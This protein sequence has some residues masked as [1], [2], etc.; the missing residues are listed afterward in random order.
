VA[1]K[2]ASATVAAAVAALILSLDM[3]FLSLVSFFVVR[4]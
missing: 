4:L 2:A 1:E 3:V